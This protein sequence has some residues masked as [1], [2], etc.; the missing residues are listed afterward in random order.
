VGD[1]VRLIRTLA[2]SGR[3]LADLS[4]TKIAQIIGEMACEDRILPIMLAGFELPQRR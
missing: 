4:K 1:S 2:G 3:F